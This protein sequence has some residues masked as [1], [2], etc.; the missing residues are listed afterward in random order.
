MNIASATTAYEAWLGQQTPLV[1]AGLQAKHAA[2]ATDEFKFL[3]ATFY[4]W[5][6][7]WPRQCAPL[8]NAPAVMSAGDLHLE[9]FGLWRS[10][11]GHWVWGI[12]DFDEAY[13]LPYTQDLTRLATSARLAI[14]AKQL[15]LDGKDACAAILAGYAEGL[16]AGAKPYVLDDEANAWLRHAAQHSQRDPAEFWNKLAAFPLAKPGQLSTEAIGALEA[17]LGHSQ[18][19]RVA[20]RTAGLGSL[21]R[22]RWVAL[23]LQGN[24]YLAW[25]A[26]GLA[27]SAWH[28][29]HAG[30]DKEPPIYF[31]RLLHSAGRLPDP[32]L[33]LAGGWILRQLLPEK[34]KLDLLL[35]PR[36]VKEEQLLAA[37]GR[38][39]AN[40]HLAHPGATKAITADLRQRSTEWLR[41]ASKEMVNAVQVDWQEFAGA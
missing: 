12:N 39:T 36:E 40:L 5:A 31:A 33:H 37:M 25:E 20:A 19:Y 24:S 30:E 2:M 10:A 32:S 14:R 9:N 34:T 28:W 38:E 35:L 1:P 27:P 21:G 17:A 11:E 6:Q 22:Q 29:A 41:Q 7:V 4:R 8:A 16:A 3:R 13:P 23:A 26:K 15:T 18:P